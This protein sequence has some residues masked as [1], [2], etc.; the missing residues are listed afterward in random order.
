MCTES[1]QSCG[2]QPRFISLLNFMSSVA[3]ARYQ[4]EQAKAYEDF[5]EPEERDEAG[6]PCGDK[7]SASA[8]ER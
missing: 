5:P 6:A 3:H 1:I 2:E 8:T 7:L 4:E